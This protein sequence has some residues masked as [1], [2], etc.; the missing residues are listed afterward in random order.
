MEEPTEQPAEQRLHSRFDCA[1]SALVHLAP[2]VTPLKSSIID[3]SLSGGLIIH[4]R[5][6]LIPDGTNLELAFTVNSLVFRVRAQVRTVRSPVAFG[7]GFENIH[8][9]V[10]LHLQDLIEELAADNLTHATKK[11]LT[12]EHKTAP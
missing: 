3:L 11:I 4:E 2:G 5:P 12:M 8:Q 1:G 6:R 7:L 9:R 10:R